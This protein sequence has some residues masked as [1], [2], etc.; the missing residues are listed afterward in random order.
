MDLLDYFNFSVHMYKQLLLEN[1]KIFD[2]ENFIVA[3]MY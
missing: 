2:A 1:K 3:V